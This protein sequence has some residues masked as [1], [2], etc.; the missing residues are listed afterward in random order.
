MSRFLDALHCR[1]CDRP[2]VWLMRQAGRYLPEY[3]AIRE[4][5]PLEQMFTSP[6]IAAQVTV[7]PIER[8][9]FDAAILFADILTPCAGFDLNVSFEGG[10]K[11]RGDWKPFEIAKL[12]HV[13]ETIGILKHELKV[14][15]IGFCGGPLTVAKYIE[16]SVDM[17]ALTD[18]SIA[19]LKMQIAAGVDAVQIFDS[20]SGLLPKEQ[21]LREALPHLKRMV[22][23]IAPFPVILFTRGACHLASELSDLGPR[24]ISFDWDRPMHA[25]RSQ[26]PKEMVVQGNLDPALLKQPKRVIEQELSKLLESM[27]DHRGFILNVGHGLTPDTPLEGVQAM[28]DTLTT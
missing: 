25:M 24:G 14:P 7:Q 28:M 23:A 9:G 17:E 20:W 15:L 8:F 26:V 22:E 5:L 4:K 21:F 12:A 3:R 16:G 1:P 19:Y 13:Q 6:E 11:V 2:P 18:A 27:R 10:P